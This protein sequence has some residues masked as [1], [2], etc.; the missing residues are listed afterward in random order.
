M[1]DEPAQDP[2]EPSS[3]PRPPN[4]SDDPR[5]AVDL[6]DPLGPVERVLD[7]LAA[8]GFSVTGR[9][10]SR[11][12]LQGEM[13]QAT[14]RG[15]D[16]KGLIYELR[17][18]GE[19]GYQVLLDPEG[20]DE[21]A[22]TARKARQGQDIG[23]EFVDVDDMKIEGTF[24]SEEIAETLRTFTGLRSGGVVP[25]SVTE[26]LEAIGYRATLRASAR[27][28]L[29]IR[30]EPARAIRRVHARGHL[31]L[32]R[33]AVERV[34]SSQGRVGA[35]VKADR[36]STRQEL[37]HDPP[38]SLCTPDDE[39]CKQ[40]ERDELERLQRFL[41]DQGYLLGRARIGLLCGRAEDEADLWV[42]V[43]KGVSY[44][45]RNIKVMG[46]M[47]S[48]DE[49]WVRRVFRPTIGP[50]LPIPKRLTRTHIDSASERVA[51]EYAEPRGSRR[52]TLALPY[53]AVRV[54]T[55]FETLGQAVAG[56][57]NDPRKVIQ[58]RFAETPLQVDVE[59][60]PGVVTE[61]AGTN[62]VAEGRLIRQIQLFER[63]EPAT[64]AAAEREAENL[65]AY[66]QT[67]GFTV[68]R[69]RGSFRSEAAL[70]RLSFQIDE[71]PRVR[72]R[73]VDFPPIEGMEASVFAA[74]EREY[75]R[76]RNM[77][78]RG[79]FTDADARED[80]S[81][82]LQE[83]AKQGYLCAQARIRLAF[84][85]GGLDQNGQYAIIDLGTEL[86]ASGDPV[87]LE[88]QLS[89]QGLAALRT[90]PNAGLYL[91]IEVD[92]GPRILT[93]PR[94][95]VTYLEIGIPKS[96]EVDNL[97][98]VEEGAWGAPRILRET[99]LRHRDDDRPGRV[100][101]RLG[102]AQETERDIQLRYRREGFPL[103]DA[104]IRWVYTDREGQVHRVAQAERLTDSQ[105][106]LCADPRSRVAEV[107]TE[108]YVYEGRRGTFGTTLIRGNFKTQTYVLRREV[109]FREGN[110]YSV[111][112]EDETRRRIEETGVVETVVVEAHPST[113]E[114]TDDPETPCVIHEVV[115]ITESKDR[116][117]DLTWGFGLATLDNFYFV[118]DPTFPNLFGSGWDLRLR[119]H[120]G[121]N[122]FRFLCDG[123][124]CY[125]RSARVSLER[126]RLF[127]SPLSFEVSGQFQRR[128]TPARGT[129]DTALGQIRMSWPFRKRKGW[130]LHWGYLIQAANLSKSIVKPILNSN[131][132]CDARSDGVCRPP[133]RREAVVPDLTGA[134]ELGFAWS[135]VDNGFNPDKGFIGG[136]DV[137]LAS[138]YLGGDDWWLQ[139]KAS[140]EQ[141][142]P[143][144]G[145]DRRLNFRYS[146]R[147]GHS[148]PLPTFPGSNTTS[149]PEVWRFFGGGTVDLGLRGI[150]PQTLLV[151]IEEIDLPYGST[152]LRRT[153]QGGHIWAL[154]TAALQFVTVKNL[155]G[156]SLAHSIFLDLAVLTQRWRDVVPLRDI[157]R[158]VGVNFVKWN[159]RIVTVS[160]GYAVLVPN[161]ILP[162]NV[163]PT[164][165][166]NGRFVFDVGATF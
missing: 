22:L 5:F 163:R 62:R 39:E 79:R 14:L 77:R 13:L 19:L 133:N 156:G 18:V 107:D 51:H 66:Y 158:S 97:P 141:F 65:R 154:G 114:L 131:Q 10:R 85:R 23:V 17:R 30:V 64:S 161:S 139:A 110:L 104:E 27:G 70:K 68:A 137:M 15:P 53:P 159:F 73:S 98:I 1:E 126:R 122:I 155:L 8:R 145:L 35:I 91:R 106:G 33:R 20:R 165:D 6:S 130:E 16:A 7:T 50:L 34:L 60:G 21:F 134:V 92:A 55:N 108:V 140:W 69:V 124:D 94:E 26:R 80:L 86:A 29:E 44:R 9:V 88:R 84:W 72:L 75:Q 41:Y 101:M 78:T 128:A 115:S 43:E 118:I 89:E 166:R 95:D 24:R 90:L 129:I 120:I 116:T 38:P 2:D 136:A 143:L 102:L 61:F 25:A 96:R 76:S 11:T 123:E 57:P 74:I 146:L 147:Y 87:W 59:L 112:Q 42:M 149:I 40:W 151:D 127:A 37:L 99:A 103:A 4:Q 157:R 71:G 100:A 105:V 47:S 52:R 49:R 109:R 111:A 160:L 135:R 67:R 82:L 81:L 56:A 45:A 150:E 119:A 164:D 113:C 32:S 48:A 125:E 144:R 142:I 121:T 138:P 153:P 162:R 148:I 54:D 3:D 132:P 83:L 46:N 36:C 31:P 117:M 28:Q 12:S 152:I 58:N 63:R 93:S